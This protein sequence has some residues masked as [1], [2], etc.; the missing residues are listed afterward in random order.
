MHYLRWLLP[1]KKRS[2]FQT[3]HARLDCVTGS[4]ELLV[5]FAARNTQKFQFGGVFAGIEINRLSLVD[6]TGL[7]WYQEGIPDFADDLHGIA[8]RINEIKRQNGFRKVTCFGG[9]MGAYA[10]VAVG[11]LA[12]VDR[13][14][15]VSPQ[16]VFN[17][18]WTYTPP[19]SVPLSPIS[20]V[21]EVRR[22]RKTRF[23]LLVSS[24]VLD[25]YHAAQL[26]GMKHVGLNFI[27]GNHN[28]L[29]N[30]KNVGLTKPMI[31]SFMNHG[32]LIAN[33][34]VNEFDAKNLRK[35]LARFLSLFYA[36]KFE[37]AAKAGREVLQFAPT[38]ADAHTFVGRCYFQAKQHHVALALFER[39]HSLDGLNIAVY[40]ELI[41]ANVHLGYIERA[42]D[43]I[44]QYIGVIQM[45]DE[46]ISRRMERLK[47]ATQAIGS[48]PINAAL[49]DAIALYGR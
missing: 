18:G 15:A 10:A 4:D 31:S 28:V 29:R 11:A 5:L 34:P 21:D 42:R 44:G 33:F 26:S 22:A 43:L 27:R 2:N 14:I 24:E 36:R 25:V 45:E 17:K 37:A 39:A 41:V 48:P 8:A 7:S 12:K 32:K 6:R 20:V 3:S 1:E 19:P 35:R 47:T 23:H 13:V 46:N 9:S 49:F 40:H 16:I 38:W 30:W